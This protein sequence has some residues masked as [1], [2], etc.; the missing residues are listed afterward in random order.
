MKLQRK[1]ERMMQV[2][3]KSA[4]ND[5]IIHVSAQF[6]YHCFDAFTHCSSP[7]L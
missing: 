4:M 6:L 1:K 5:V 2:I 3:S 7:R